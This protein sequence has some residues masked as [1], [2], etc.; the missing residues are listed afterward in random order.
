MP[1]PGPDF[2][3][4]E[5]PVVVIRDFL[6]RNSK[7]AWIPEEISEHTGINVT[8]TYNI[9]QLLRAKYVESTAKG[10]YFPIRSI[11]RLGQTY[12]KWMIRNRKKI[13]K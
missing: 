13:N 6:K 5:D 2:D 11:E 1:I 12:F 3:S 10:E 8:T 7:D 4:V 9:C